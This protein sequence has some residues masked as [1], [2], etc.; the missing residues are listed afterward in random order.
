M[1]V[2]VANTHYIRLRSIL[3]GMQLFEYIYEA[4]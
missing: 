2:N 4:Y 1:Q 3:I